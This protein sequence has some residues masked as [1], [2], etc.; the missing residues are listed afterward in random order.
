M[1]RLLLEC[2]IRAALVVGG[3]ALVLRMMRIRR[4]AMRHAAW[5]GV[6]V[7]MLALPFWSLVGPKLSVP[8]LQTAPAPAPAAPPSASGVVR[9]TP[10]TAAATGVFAV[11]SGPDAPRPTTEMDWSGVLVALYLA[12]A[13]L[14]L[15]RLGVGTFY[16]RRLRRDATI[17]D[18]RA[19]T[20]ACASPITV[21]WFAPALILPVGWQ[22]WPAAKLD[23]V[24]I[25]EGEHARRHDPLVQWI[26]LLN[27]AVFWFHP[28][29]WWLERRLATLAEESC[30]AAVVAAGHSPD[31][32][33][34]Y[35]LD[36]ARA[37]TDRRR[38]I[39]AVGMAMPGS[40]LHERMT[41]ILHGAPLPPTS[42]ARLACTVVLCAASTGLFAG[43]TPTP[44]VS[45][46]PG[47]SG[48]AST[49]P[50]PRPVERAASSHAPGNGASQTPATVTPSFDVATIKPCP[51]GADGRGGPG[52]GKHIDI[53]L[54]RAYLQC[55]SVES[56]VYL[57]F[58]R[59]GEVVLNEHGAERQIRGGP[60][61]MRSELYTIEATAGPRGLEAPG[62]LGQ[63]LR[64]LLEDRFQLR[65][66]R[67]AESV[68]MYALT[69]AK[70]GLKIAPIG[71]DGCVED[72]REDAAPSRPGGVGVGQPGKKPAC[73][74]VRGQRRGSIRVWDLGGASLKALADVL[75]TDREVLDETGVT[76]R[77]NIHLEYA[78]DEPMQAATHDAADAPSDRTGTAGASVFRA[79]EEQLGLKLVSTRGPREY[80]VIDRIERP[81]NQ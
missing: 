20:D 66:H 7:V 24:L 72:E 75:D 67:L 18:G 64:A 44:R 71:D 36:L 69:V 78:L 57:A 17:Q 8:V 12:G 34:D 14:L 29:A 31:D 55:F 61:W 37:V 38:R 23:A 60:G 77:F 10:Q 58:A 15:T 80:V 53:S 41:Q 65:S 74:G 3:T 62:A 50:A 40:G 63:K 25:H 46:P 76:G 11:R 79:L 1:A 9:A 42:R 13:I 33:A 19:T 45:L 26:A 35:L 22:Q 39:R 49:S 51:P 68:P 5:A 21:G 54:S 28:L 32:Y 30:D 70:G 56:L 6:V 16:A 73:G 4:A 2:A 43:A 81:S 27:R 59:N 47:A 52:G 48:L